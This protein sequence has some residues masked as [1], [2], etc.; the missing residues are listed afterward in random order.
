MMSIW[1]QSIFTSKRLSYC[2]SLPL[3]LSHFLNRCNNK[4]LISLEFD[5]SGIDAPNHSFFI[6]F[7]QS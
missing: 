2:G 3:S 6:W 4:Q 7:Y 1:K 5:R